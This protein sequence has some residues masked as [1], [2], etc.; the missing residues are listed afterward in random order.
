[1]WFLVLSSISA[2]VHFLYGA[3]VIPANAFI[4]VYWITVESGSSFAAAWGASRHRNT[5]KKETKETKY[6]VGDTERINNTMATLVILS[7]HAQK[8]TMSS[9]DRK[10]ATSTAES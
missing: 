4:A 7:D 6:K 5:V 9:A 2:T 8:E 1:M 10:M 3:D